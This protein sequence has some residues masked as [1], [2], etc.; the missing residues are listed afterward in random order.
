MI[1]T[2]LINVKKNRIDEFFKIIFQDFS[3]ILLI[4]FLLSEE[5]FHIIH[6]KIY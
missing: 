1:F 2:F 5:P 4:A 3:Y 6:R